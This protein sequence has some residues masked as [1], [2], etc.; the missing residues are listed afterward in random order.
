MVVAMARGLGRE[1]DGGAD[2]STGPR[3]ARPGLRAMADLT[4]PAV[5]PVALADEVEGVALDG[6]DGGGLRGHG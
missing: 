6:G 4:V 2:G 3:S 5:V 1:R